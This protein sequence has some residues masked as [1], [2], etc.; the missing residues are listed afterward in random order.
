MKHFF[1]VI[2]CTHNRA[3]LLPRALDSLL[4][5][6]ESDWE[7]IVVDDGS[8]DQTVE[9]VKGYSSICPNIRLFQ[10]SFNRGVAAARNIGVKLSEGRFI[11]FLDSDDEYAVDHLAVRRSI[12][13]S[14]DRIQM[15]HGGLRIV[16]DP[17]VADKDKPG[18]KIHLSKCEVGGTFVVKRSVFQEIG[19]FN[20]LPYAE[21]SCFFEMAIE[22]QIHCQAV[23][24]PSYIYYRNTNGQLTSQKLIDS[25]DHLSE[26]I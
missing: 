1:N 18:E 8:T 23:T 22:S 17:F 13:S 15:L 3:P 11:T 24:H 25:K 14:D 12:L 9:V 7:A 19:G 16:G 10:R 21:D 6:S 4:A 2:I 26:R 5:Q 20:D